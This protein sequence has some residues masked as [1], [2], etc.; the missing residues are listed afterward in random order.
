[1]GL[2]LGLYRYSAFFVTVIVRYSARYITVVFVLSPEEPE[3]EPS[4]LLVFQAVQGQAAVIGDTTSE[5]RVALHS[6]LELLQT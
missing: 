4:G 2:N 1:M 3:Q 5:L 6:Q